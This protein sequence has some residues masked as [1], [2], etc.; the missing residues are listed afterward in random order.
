MPQVKIFVLVSIFSNHLSTSIG[1]SL[2]FKYKNSIKYFILLFFICFGF[3]QK[4]DPKTGKLI[5]KVQ[6]DPKTGEIIREENNINGGLIGKEVAVNLTSGEKL[7]GKLIEITDTQISIL[8]STLGSIKLQQKNVQNLYLKDALTTI[9]N[10]SKNIIDED[11]LNNDEISY[12]RVIDR[13]KSEALFNNQASTNLVVGATGC[14]FGAIGIPIALIIANSETGFKKPSSSYYNN[15]NDVD[16]K[17]Y[18]SAYIKEAKKL[19]R[20]GITGTMTGC[21]GIALILTG[22][23]F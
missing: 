10:L 4:Y 11:G 1:N 6:Y 5:E 22:I 9:N 8:S 3:A 20:N 16:K 15:L 21:F 12:S 2:N 14:L 23:G 13:A 18:N 19:R 17:T 7:T